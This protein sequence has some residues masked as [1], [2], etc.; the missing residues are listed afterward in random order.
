MSLPTTARQWVLNDRPLG[1]SVRIEDFKLIEAPVPAPKDGEV[2]IKTLYLGF[3]PAQK[4]FME[5]SANYM[6]PLGIGEPMLGTGLGQV[7]KSRSPKFREGDYVRG[8]LCWQEY[9]CF[10]DTGTDLPLDKVSDEVPLT[11]HLSVLHTTGLTAYI[12]L[13]EIGKPIAGDTVVVSGAAGATGSVACQ[14]AKLAGCKVVGIAGGPDKCAWLVDEIGCDA[15]IDYKNEN[16]RARLKETTKGGINVFYDNVG[17][18]ILDECLG[19]LAMNARV[20]IC[21]GISR[22]EKPNDEMPPGPRNYFNLVFMRARMEGFI[23]LDYLPKFPEARKRLARWI[24]EGKLKYSEDIQEGFENTP[25]TFLRLFEG[26]NV[27]KQLLK[28]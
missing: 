20:V 25:A 13:T 3:D 10:P 15:A 2:L 27:G 9:A 4:G 19:R 18:D 23:V 28:L 16:V 8:Q 11:A 22:Y 5:N 7:I 14:I 6:R 17:G 21:G 1:R 12:G 24:K 26:K